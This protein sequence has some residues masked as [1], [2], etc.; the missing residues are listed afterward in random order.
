MPDVGGVFSGVGA[1]GGRGRPRLH[2]ANKGFRFG[3]RFSNGPGAH[4]NEQEAVTGRQKGDLIDGEALAAHEVEE[5]AVKAFEADGAVLEHLRHGVGGEE[6]VGESERGEDAVRGAVSKVERGGDEGGAGAF[7]A[8][9]GAGHVEVV[10]GQQLVEVVAGDAARDARKASADEVGVAVADAREAGVDLTD[11]AALADEA[12]KLGGRGGADGEARAVVEDEIHGLDVVDDLAAEQAVGAAGVVADHAAEG[13]AGVGSGVG[14][15]GEVVDSAASRRRSRMMPGSTR[16]SARRGRCPAGRSCSGRSR[17]RRR[18][19]RF[20]RRARCRHH[21]EGPRPRW[22]GRL[23]ARLRRRPRR[24]GR[25]RRWGA[26]GSWKRRLRR[27]H[28]C[29]GRRARLRGA[30]SEARFKLAMGG[31]S[32][33][34]QR[35]GVGRVQM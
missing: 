29:R 24:A 7:A 4:F 25:R 33:V 14:R 28:G 11:A 16:A 3:L 26:G 27:G 10:L 30:A 12:L 35:G 23:R 13:A 5:Q 34:I 22:R 17:R 6:G 2:G 18:R 32:L 9:E 1:R 31:K 19:W 8:D 15:V 20:G 21:A